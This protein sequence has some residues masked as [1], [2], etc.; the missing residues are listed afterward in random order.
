MT[1]EPT[2]KK[3]CMVTVA[4]VLAICGLLLPPTFYLLIAALPSMPVFAE[5]MGSDLGCMAVNIF[6]YASFSLPPILVLVSVVLAFIARHRIKK[7]PNTPGKGKAIAASFCG[8]VTIALWVFVFV[9]PSL[10]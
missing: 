6:V 9:L 10:K 5:L 2:T 1:T 7:V 3:N 4:L 8:Y